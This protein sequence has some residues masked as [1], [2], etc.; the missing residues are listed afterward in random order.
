MTD[1]IILTRATLYQEAWRAL[2]SGQP[3]IEVIGTV[4]QSQ[5]LHRFVSQNHQPITILI[6]LALPDPAVAH[7]IKEITPTPGRLFLVDVYDLAEMV[8]LLQA[9][10]AGCLNREATVADLSR[11]I[12]A[13]GRGEILLPSE[14]ATKA[15][16]ALARG[17]VGG[18]RPS[19]STLTEREQ[20][21]LRLLAQGMT[22]KD[23]AQSLFLSV[24]TI[25]A[26]LRNIY[27][28]LAVATR[29]EAVLWA[30]QHGYKP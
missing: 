29:T 1:L 2:L 17:E 4:S 25:E 5:D 6:D 8:T 21:V 20:D 15:L 13:A 26:H 10:A 19:S 11:G 27:G 30:V 22:N 18:K 23:I 3:G 14:W 28:K 7:Q 24:R 12:I 9:G 16:V